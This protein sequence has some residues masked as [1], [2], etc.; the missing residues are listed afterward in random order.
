MIWND[1]KADQKI[2][3]KFKINV[4]YRGKMIEQLKMRFLNKFKKKNVYV[5]IAFRFNRIN[6][7]VLFKYL[8]TSFAFEKIFL[9]IIIKMKMM[10]NKMKIKAIAKKKKADKNERIKKKIIAKH[11]CINVKCFK[12]SENVCYIKAGKNWHWSLT[13]NNINN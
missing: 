13:K 7:D 4:K 11:T 8:K 12:Y 3:S 9:M 10:Q 2:I 6:I 5:R 1:Q